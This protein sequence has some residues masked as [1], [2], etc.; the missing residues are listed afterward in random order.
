M[1]A[2]AG[3]R[4][5]ARTRLAAGLACAGVLALAGCM[6]IPTSGPVEAGEVVL[7]EQG[8]SIPIAYGP[9][10]DA[11]PEEIVNGF[12]RAAAVGVY[13]DYA[14]AMEFLTGTAAKQWRPRTTI[15]IY[16]TGVPQVRM[17]ESDG[18]AAVSVEASAT[19]D[20]AG[21]YTES[22]PDAA[23]V[24]QDLVLG[25]NGAGQ[26][27][28]TDLPDGVLMSRSGFETSHREVGI[29]FATL[30]RAALVPEMRWFAES[31][32]LDG[33]V[34]ALVAGPSPW[35][36]DGVVTGVPDGVR[37][38][39]GVLLDSD[40]TVTVNLT[41]NLANPADS[42]DRSLLQAQ[43]VATI[44]STHVAFK[45]VRVTVND[46]SSEAVET[47]N[48]PVDPAPTGGPYVLAAGTDG[49]TVLAEVTGGEVV[50]VEGAAPLTGLVASSPAVS[51]DGTIRAVL[52][53]GQRLV[54]LPPDSAPPVEVHAG[55]ALLAPSV[56]RY[57]WIWT[58]ERQSVGALAAVSAS[59]EVVP[60]T[61]DWLAGREVRSVRVSRDGSRI[62]V[63]YQSPA[64]PSVIEV[65]SVVRDD[66]GRPQSL[67]EE[68]LVVGASLTDVTEVAWLDAATLAVLGTGAGA[69]IPTAYTVPLG[70][71]TSMK[72]TVAGARGIAAA[73]E[74]LY[75]VDETGSLLLLRGQTSTWTAVVTGVRDPVL[76]G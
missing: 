75:L 32:L 42:Q 50:P 45:G 62:A 72:P 65:A 44:N 24:K 39:A 25:Q 53:G 7:P 58:G 59:G 3:A 36:R 21:R 70:G 9:T 16:D 73:P 56:D 28:I 57:G 54:V 33:A 55:T 63:A 61:A 15:T 5:L 10:V 22:P 23:A 67:G 34:Q 14:T 31:K 17:V 43:L 8:T 41:S 71:R 64:G 26:W 37:P 1:R 40:N 27:R 11:S 18:V 46:Q 13:D 35:L 19:V 68:R 74:T 4:S 6:G 60:V 66:D 69:E 20:D 52:D 2:R 29:Y 38:P 48:L 47:L 30:D 12:L 49:T 51:L 76:G